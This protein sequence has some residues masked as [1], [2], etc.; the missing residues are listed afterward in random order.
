MFE[1]SWSGSLQ[2]EEHLQRTYSDPGREFRLLNIEGLTQPTGP[3]EPFD[4]PDMQ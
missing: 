4:P 1:Q 3:T 2:L